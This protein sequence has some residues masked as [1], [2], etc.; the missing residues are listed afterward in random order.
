MIQYGLYIDLWRIIA[1]I[2]V[3]KGKI[4]E[5]ESEYDELRRRSKKSVNTICVIFSVILCLFIPPSLIVGL[6][7]CSDTFMVYYISFAVCDF[8]SI[9][10]MILYIFGAYRKKD[11]KSMG[12]VLSPAIVVMFILV[13]GSIAIYSAM[14]FYIS[15][16]YVM[17]AWNLPKPLFICI[18]TFTLSLSDFIVMRACIE[19]F[20]AW[21]FGWNAQ[22]N[23]YA[24]TEDES[25]ETKIIDEIMKKLYEKGVV[26]NDEVKKDNN[27]K[28]EIAIKEKVFKSDKS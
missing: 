6:L 10:I 11:K 7:F 18:F 3:L 27:S 9:I 5:N 28:C 17:I 1:V 22:T 26:E 12:Y 4:L 13:L 20:K 25:E 8:V 2:P 16:F 23:S 14:V 21:R 19:W 15:I 24:E